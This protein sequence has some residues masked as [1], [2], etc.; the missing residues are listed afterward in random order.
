VGKGDIMKCKDCYWYDEQSNTE[1]WCLE[2]PP[3]V[4]WPTRYTSPVYIPPIVP[5]GRRG[6]SKFKAK[7]EG[8]NETCDTCQ[9]FGRRDANL[10]Y[11]ECVRTDQSRK[12][13]ETCPEWEK[14]NG[15]D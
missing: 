13:T 9:N 10:M 6:C 11:G 5:F 15:N 7:G 8:V 1:G 14:F 12:Y 3:V 4:L 2:S